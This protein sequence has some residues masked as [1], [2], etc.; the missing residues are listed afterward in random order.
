VLLAL[1]ASNQVKI[2]EQSRAMSEATDK[3]SVDELI[4]QAIARKES[5][6]AEKRQQQQ[7]AD[8]AEQ[9]LELEKFTKQIEVDISPV[10]LRAIG[11]RYEVEQKDRA[12]AGRYQGVAKFPITDETDRVWDIRLTYDSY[13][14]LQMSQP[15]L[16]VQPKYRSDEWRSVSREDG[17][18]GDDFLLLNIASWKLQVQELKQKAEAEQ[19][20]AERTMQRRQQEAEQ[21]RQQREREKQEEAHYQAIV[22]QQNAE[23]LAQLE[24]HFWTFE[25]KQPIVIYKC[26]WSQGGYTDSDGQTD[27]NRVS[28]YTL[29]DH[30]DPD[31][32]I[33]AVNTDRQVKLDMR[34]HQPVF[35]RLIFTS[36]DS[37]LQKFGGDRQKIKVYGIRRSPSLDRH[38]WAAEE[39]AYAIVAAKGLIPADWA[40]QAFNLP[41]PIQT[42]RL[43]PPADATFLEA[44]PEAEYDDL[45]F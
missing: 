42:A 22:E 17:Q 16:Y 38:I 29:A 35:N 15:K 34:I 28:I 9:R 31:G 5:A 10:V 30:L 12:G 24:P 8:E 27:F 1:S 26:E 13:G 41:V 14:R 4:A 6:E 20:E 2:T 3:P 21:R 40:I 33:H 11:V 39:E 19:Q 43:T 7:Q 32:W 18:T 25:F 45:P 36:L 23:I 37:F 44:E